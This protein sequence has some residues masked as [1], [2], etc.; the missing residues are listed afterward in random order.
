MIISTLES[1]RLAQAKAAFT[2]RH[3]DF[4][5]IATIL[6]GDLA[7]QVGDLVLAKVETLGQ[8]KNI[9]LPEG[10]KAILFPGDEVIVCYG[11]RYAP[12]QFEAEIPEDLSQC[13]LAA[14][15]GLAA[16]VL[17]QHDKMNSPTVLTPIGLL[18]DQDGNRINLTD[19]ALK[20]T[21][22][23]GQRP[24][25]LAVVGACMNAGKT[26]T[27]ANLIQG[28]KASGMKVGAAKVTGTGAGGDIWLMRDAG[29]NPVLDFTDAGFPSTYRLDLKQVQ[30]IF[31]TLT[32]HLAAEDVDAIVI[33][34]ADGLFQD[35]TAML[36]SSL[37]FRNEVD[38]VIFA[39][40]SAL[41]VAAG[42]EWLER[43]KLPVLAVS[44]VVSASPL[45]SRETERVTK[46]PVLNIE[47]LR[48]PE[49]IATL[50]YQRQ[51][52][53]A[54]RQPPLSMPLQSTLAVSL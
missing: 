4:E 52:G 45:A 49:A 2:T 48:N 10:R 37:N 51:A 32:S 33:E 43:W 16:K 15:G 27:A 53:T 23:I 11:N 28:L 25:T 39:A 40:G 35:E 54:M 30:E 17:C 19:W 7:P 50:D 22:Y 34:V 44:G 31:T 3:V 8:H 9:E 13:H 18:G 42:V 14:A 38:G 46:L 1:N 41:G 29:A 24:L 20:P 12:D 36:V 6:T 26:T 47:T 21:S 5:T